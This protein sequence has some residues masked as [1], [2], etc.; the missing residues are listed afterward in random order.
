[1]RAIQRAMLP[2]Y[3][4]RSPCLILVR[5]MKRAHG[6]R[7]ERASSQVDSPTFGDT[8]WRCFHCLRRCLRQNLLL[9]RPGPDARA[10]AFVGKTGWRGPA[11]LGP[12]RVHSSMAGVPAFLESL[13]SSEEWPTQEMVDAIEPQVS[14]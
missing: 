1:M 14:T 10:R 13:A 12:L 11:G 8:M 4:S 2:F 3:D 9:V 6:A 7:R 5:L